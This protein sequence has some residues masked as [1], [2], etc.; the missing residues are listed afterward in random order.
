[1]NSVCQLVK[2]T[3]KWFL[4]YRYCTEILALLPFT[5]PDEPLYL[6]YAINRVIQVRAG[7]VESNMKSMST[8]LLQRGAPKMPQENGMVQEE[9]AQPGF[10]YITQ[11]DFNGRMKEDSSGQPTFFCMSSIDLNGTMQ[12]EPIHHTISHH[13]PE[14]VNQTIPHC[15]EEKMRDTRSD[16]SCGISKD[17]LEK[18]QVFNYIKL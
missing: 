5:S 1:M 11:T 2:I 3:L 7:A 9:S 15:T 16:E 10:N 4:F 13:I 14:P 12:P 18:M 6:I 17:D 8:H